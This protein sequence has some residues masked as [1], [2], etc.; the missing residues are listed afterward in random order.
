M[1]SEEK[2]LRDILDDIENERLVLPT[3]P[4]VALRV[5]DTV[6]DESATAEQITAVVGQ[7]AAL[8]A[9]LLQI[10]N[11][12]LYRATNPID[13]L[14]VA[15]ARMGNDQV[16]NLVSSLIMQQMFQARPHHEKD[17]HE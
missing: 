15:I 13:N 9:K 12:P 11:S 7:D 17:T 16:R 2:F 4:E 6:E 5:R 14:Q 1:D 10:A 8:S 3:L